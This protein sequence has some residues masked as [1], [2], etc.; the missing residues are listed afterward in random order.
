MKTDKEIN[1]NITNKKDAKP[2]INYLAN[3]TQEQSKSK[4][5]K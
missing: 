2:S 5:K 3:L 1:T 4:N